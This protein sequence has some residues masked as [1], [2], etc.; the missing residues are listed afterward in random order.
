MT[1][2][3]V[4]I[5]LGKENVVEEPEIIKPKKVKPK[6]N[7]I[8]DLK[9]RLKELEDKLDLK[10]SIEEKEEWLDLTKNFIPIQEKPVLSKDVIEKVQSFKENEKTLEKITVNPPV[11][12][13]KSRFRGWILWL[14]IMASWM[15]LSLIIGFIMNVYVKIKPI[16][17]FSFSFIAMSGLY[18]LVAFFFRPKKKK[19]IEDRQIGYENL[20][21]SNITICPECNSKLS[22]GKIIESSDKLKQNIKCKNAECTFQRLVEFTK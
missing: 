19:A 9:S 15:A 1:D 18:F 14:F 20:E 12:N 13:K 5:D 2:E 8:D 11:N 4:N 6:N 3:I 21:I 7:E 22:R 10:D 17:A 16:P